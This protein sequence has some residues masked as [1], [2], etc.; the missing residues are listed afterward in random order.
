MTPA[1]MEAGL[2]LHNLLQGQGIPAA[3]VSPSQTNSGFNRRSRNIAE[4]YYTNN[5]NGP[6]LVNAGMTPVEAE[7]ALRMHNLLQGIPASQAQVSPSQTNSG[8]NRRNRNT[9]DDFDYGYGY[10]YEY[11][12][13]S[14][15]SPFVVNAGMTAEEEQFAINAHNLLGNGM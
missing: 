11:D 4:D 5:G 13:D 9:V 12:Y 14:H 15:S 8:F 3:Q 6:V 1:E 2:R 10:G 7:A